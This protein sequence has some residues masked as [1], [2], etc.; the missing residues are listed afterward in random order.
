MSS[1]LPRDHLLTWSI[2]LA[3]VQEGYD[4][5]LQAITS[6]SESRLAQAKLER[7]RVEASLTQR[8][9]TQASLLGEQAEAIKLQEA[10]CRDARNEAWSIGQRLC[11]QEER[12]LR[13]EAELKAVTLSF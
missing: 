3:A 4:D 6:E 2:V 9:A 12:R 7:Q 5:E 1:R 8:V 13:L 11:E 10:A